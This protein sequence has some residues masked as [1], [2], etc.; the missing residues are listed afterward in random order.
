MWN[1]LKSFAANLG[2]IASAMLGL[3]MGFLLFG[4]I[5]LGEIMKGN[6]L[7]LFTLGNVPIPTFIG[8]GASNVEVSIFCFIGM[9]AILFGLI[10]RHLYL[11]DEY[12]FM[13]KHGIS[14]KDVDR[15]I[16]RYSD[17]MFD[18]GGGDP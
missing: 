8:A 7:E 5:S 1:E 6:A 17:G 2:A 10:R 18:D 11:R 4:V 16:D 14:E 13:R 3:S 12:D 9:V 15:R